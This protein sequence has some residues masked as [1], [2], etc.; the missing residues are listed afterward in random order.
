MKPIVICGPTASGK[1]ELALEIA[2]RLG[3][4]ILS[5]DSRQVY[6]RL[7]AGTAKPEGSWK[8][9]VYTVEGIPYYLVDFLDVTDTFNAGNFCADV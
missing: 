2:R 9:N 8:N 5:A 4:I 3:G 6:K 7:T 1:T